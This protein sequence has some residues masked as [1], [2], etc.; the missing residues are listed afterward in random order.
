MP[1]VMKPSIQSALTLND[2]AGFH[3]VDTPQLRSAE[4]SLAAHAMPVKNDVQ[5][6]NPILEALG[7]SVDSLA[8]MKVP[9]PVKSLSQIV[10]DPNTRDITIDQYTNWAVDG[11]MPENP[12]RD[13][14]R[15]ID[16][17]K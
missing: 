5:Y 6:R 4:A 9:N 11:T 7:G 2:L 17:Q 3:V 1:G 15:Y 13:F 16:Q 12:T 10:K 8:N 14:L